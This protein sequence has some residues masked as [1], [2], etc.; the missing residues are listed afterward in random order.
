MSR[1]VR[2][3]KACSSKSQE[4]TVAT[5]K[6]HLHDDESVISGRYHTTAMSANVADASLCTSGACFS[7]KGS[8]LFNR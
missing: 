5:L 8:E 4:T 3:I 1:A 7:T 2:S 6:L